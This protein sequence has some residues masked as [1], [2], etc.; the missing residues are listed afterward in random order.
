MERRAKRREKARAGLMQPLK[1]EPSQTVQGHSYI[2]LH[3]I[4]HTGDE[5][6]RTTV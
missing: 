1:V 3:S 5:I 4:Y 2:H 6:T